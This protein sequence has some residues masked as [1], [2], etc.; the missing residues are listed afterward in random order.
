MKPVVVSSGREALDL[1]AKGRVFD[2]AVLDMQMPEMDNYISKPIKVEKLYHAL[3][4]CKP[5]PT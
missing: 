4:S 5:V 1:L 2:F 3:V